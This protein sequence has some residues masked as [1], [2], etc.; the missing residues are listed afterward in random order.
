MRRRGAWLWW[1]LLAVAPA[2]RGAVPDERAA[3]LLERLEQ[4][5]AKLDSLKAAFTQTRVFV[6]FDERESREGELKFLRG[7][8]LGR[9]GAQVQVALDPA[10]SATVQ[11]GAV[12][13]NNDG[14]LASLGY[15]TT[16]TGL[17]AVG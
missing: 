15:A 4:A 10:S 2:A 14:T 9:G 17:D 16:Q 12:V 6:H 7:V 1:L 13:D 11:I 3:A 8:G 5:Q